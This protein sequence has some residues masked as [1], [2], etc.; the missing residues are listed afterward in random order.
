MVLTK[1]EATDSDGTSPFN[2]VKYELIG[3]SV[4]SLRYFSINHDDGSISIKDDLR[5]EMDT[6]YFLEVRAYD[7]GDPPLDSVAVVKINVDHVAT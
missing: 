1:L 5:K 7:L 4:K 2:K 6:E 3:R